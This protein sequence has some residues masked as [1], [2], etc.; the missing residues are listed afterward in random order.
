MNLRKLCF[1]TTAASTAT[2]VYGTLVEANRLVV[3]EVETRLPNWPKRLDGFKI[4]LLADFHLRDKYSL[5]L[6]KD[7]VSATL[8]AQPDFVALAGDYVGYW[9]DESP[10]LLGEALE[11]L[12]LMDARVVAVPGNHD[13]WS[14][15]AA[16]L[17]P[18]FDLLNI[19]LLR[20]E[21][22]NKGG[23]T[24]VG[25]DSANAHRAEPFG[26]MTEA[27]ESSDPI[28]CLWHEPDMVDYLPAGASL[29]L[30][31]HS[32]GGQF[33]FPGGWTPMHTKNGERYVRGW[34][35]SAPT[36][37]YVSRGLGTTGPPARL[38]C[39]P[40]VTILTLRSPQ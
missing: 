26:P 11:Q 34:F 39:P 17:G 12:L 5:R 36:P 38:G 4:A 23:V 22:W 3:E 2:L 24:W 21:V 28:V 15:D 8:D 35:P 40:E 27:C 30:S 19:R 37:L 9:K 16:L 18:V 25:I 14:G 6:A 1:W 33:T 29:M 20:N 32:H 7:A 31:G 13:Y 10:W